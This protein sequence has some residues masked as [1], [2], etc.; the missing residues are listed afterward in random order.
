MKRLLIPTL[1]L[2]LS[3]CAGSQRE[4]RFDSATAQVDLS[5]E[6]PGVH[7]QTDADGVILGFTWGLHADVYGGGINDGLSFWVY[8]GLVHEHSGAYVRLDWRFM[9]G[10][11]RICL[12]V[13]NP[14][15]E[16]NFEICTE[17]V[18]V[19][20]GPGVIRTAPLPENADAL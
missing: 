3:A 12:G 14:T 13:G 11:P 20:I 1:L 15:L 16:G 4:T 17:D 9:Q 5:D 8:V 7:L 10:G 6:G 19:E 18:P 2:A